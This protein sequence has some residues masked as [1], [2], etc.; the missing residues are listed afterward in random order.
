MLY[1][2]TSR[3]AW[4]SFLPVSAELDRAIM[5]ALSTEDLICQD[6]EKK[7]KRSHQAVSG[8]LRHLVEK[9][10]VVATG[11]YGKT[12]SGRRAKKWTIAL[13]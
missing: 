1:Q 3:D 2:P 12:S 6:I 5:E 9:G 13:A 11:D 8:N 7:I 10:A 4:R